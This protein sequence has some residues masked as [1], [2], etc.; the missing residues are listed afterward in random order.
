MNFWSTVIPF[1]G[2]VFTAYIAYLAATKAKTID[3]TSTP[4]DKVITRVNELEEDIKTVRRQLNV[5]VIDRDTLARFIYNLY[6]WERRGRSFDRP[7]MPLHLRDA[8]K[9]AGV[10]WPHCDK[11]GNK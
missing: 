10:P 9:A 2:S 8:F 3:S 4:Y 7:T 5:V 1:L 6:E 11:E